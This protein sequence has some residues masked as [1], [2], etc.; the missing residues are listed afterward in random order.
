MKIINLCLV[1]LLS[2]VSH[3]TANKIKKT[4]YPGRVI[5]YNARP[6]N[7]KDQIPNEEQLVAFYQ[8]TAQKSLFQRDR[9][10]IKVENQ[11]TIEGAISKTAAR[12][13]LEKYTVYRD[14]GRI[15][16]RK[17][18]IWMDFPKEKTESTRQEDST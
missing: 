12:K 17:E 13:Y 16:S 9:W 4:T 5:D 18:R 11:Q 3:S 6:V 14:R 8:A 15:D 10:I 7:G 2:V 1:L